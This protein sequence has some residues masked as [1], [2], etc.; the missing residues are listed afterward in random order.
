MQIRKDGR[1]RPLGSFTVSGES[2]TV[3]NTLTGPRWVGSSV[4]LPSLVDL[5][6]IP[7]MDVRRKQPLERRIRIWL[8]ERADVASVTDQLWRDAPR[9][10]GQVDDPG[11]HIHV[12]TASGSPVT[13]VRPDSTGRFQMRLRPGS[14]RAEARASADRSASLEF[15]VDEG[16]DA[17]SLPPLEVGA[18]AWV[19]L[20]P[21]FRGRLVFLD[22]ASGEPAVFGRDR[23]GFRLGDEVFP[24]ALQAPFYNLGGA[25]D[26]PERIAIEP[27]RYRVLAT[28]GPEH[29]VAE[30]RLETRR[31]EETALAL[32]PLEHVRPTPGWISADLHVHSGESFDAATPQRRQLAAFAASGTE[33]LVATEHDRVFDPRPA[34]RAAGLSGELVALTGVEVTGTFKGADAPHSSGHWN[35]FPLAARPKAYRGGAPSLEGRRP[36]DVFAEVRRRSPVPFVQLNH[37]RRGVVLGDADTFFSHLG[38]AEEDYDPTRWLTQQPNLNLLRADPA[39]GFADL[40][41][42]G[43]ELLNS[44]DLVRYR[45]VRA[46]W[47]SLLLQGVYKVA[48]A[49]SDSHTWGVIVG[50]PRNYVEVRGDDVRTFSESELLA[51]LRAGRVYGSTGPILDVRLDETGMGGLHRGATGVLEVKVEAA[52]WIPIGE[53][54]AYLNGELIHRASIEAGGAARLPLAFEHDGF[55]TVEVEGPVEGRYAELLPGFVPFAFGNPIFVDVDGNGRYDAPGIPARPP[56]TLA[57][58]DAEDRHTIPL[59]GNEAG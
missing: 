45:R 40:D 7:F 34:L 16:S 55:V 38:V 28:R 36:R 12:S 20:P 59:V 13:M 58:P 57:D 44:P 5:A 29:A 27:G 22:E 10:E 24:A 4:D 14:Y 11:A 1:T 17:S 9:V 53:W 46:D 47:F 8:G 51:S 50:L 48:T 25:A 30:T 15:R 54:R 26:D 56:A 52:P 37:P 33:V 6:R 42:D 41:F 31:G 21:D 32:D 23:L 43:V 35:V 49:N 18:P 2:F 39:H 3:F 19:R